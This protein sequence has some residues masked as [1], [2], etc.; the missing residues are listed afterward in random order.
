MAKISVII[1]V[2]NAEKYIKT[3]LDSILNQ[4]FKDI[5]I[6]LVNDGSLDESLNICKRYQENDRR[7]I[8]LDKKNE[9]VSIARNTGIEASRDRK[10]VV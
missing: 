10:S 1:P 6:I 9:G 5:E 2:Y 7:I 3:T 8:V 4:T